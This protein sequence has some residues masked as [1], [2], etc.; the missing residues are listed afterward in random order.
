MGLA[1]I[2]V[3]CFSLIFVRLNQIN[4]NGHTIISNALG[5]QVPQEAGYSHV[6]NKGDQ[7]ARYYGYYSNGPGVN[8]KIKQG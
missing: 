1:I 5:G 3:I 6:P 4:A 8:G 2:S 7:M